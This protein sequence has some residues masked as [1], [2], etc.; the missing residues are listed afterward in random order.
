LYAEVFLTSKSKFS[1]PQ[2][3]AE[4]LEILLFCVKKLAKTLKIIPM[5]FRASISRLDK[6][7][8]RAMNL[9]GWGRQA[10]A[11]NR[12]STVTFAD[13]VTMVIQVTTLNRLLVVTLA[14]EIPWQYT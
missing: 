4:F 10:T 8:N 11:P 12:K 3:A 1:E 9:C 5:I 13:E 2:A 7:K 14:T 6:K